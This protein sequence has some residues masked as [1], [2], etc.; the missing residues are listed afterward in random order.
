MLPSSLHLPTGRLLHPSTIYG[1]TFDSSLPLSGISML[2][3]RPRKS[4]EGKVGA[5][6]EK[7]KIFVTTLN[8]SFIPPPIFG[9]RAVRFRRDFHFGEE[10]PVYF[11][12]PFSHRIAHLAVIPYPSPDPSHKHAIAWRVLG[13]ED[14]VRLN[15]ADPP[16]ILGHLSESVRVAIKKA[17]DD[18]IGKVSA[19]SAS[20]VLSLADQELWKND[21]YARSYVFSL[22]CL[23]ARL[24]CPASFKE[25]AMA[26]ALCQRAYLE[27]VARLSW[28]RDFLPH[29]REP[30]SVPSKTA[31]VVGAL[32]GDIETCERLYRAGIPV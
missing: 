25:S 13:P 19:L 3:S 12:Q 23:L 24:S 28:F 27:L 15:V 4:H 5:V 29:V 22:K 11:P 16:S 9:E 32:T 21:K 1:S 6:F 17:V 2:S 10:D 30:S 14:F 20:G 18:V 31:N 7:E 26:F 8:Q